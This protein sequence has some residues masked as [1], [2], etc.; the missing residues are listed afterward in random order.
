[1]QNSQRFNP[2]TLIHGADYNPE[3]WALVPGIWDA[4]MRLLGEARLNCVSLGIFSWAELESDEGVYSFEWMDEMMDRL[5]TNG[6]K[7]ILATPS[8][9]KPNW[10]A[11]KYPEIRRVGEDGRRR[12]QGL[13]HNH[14]LTSPIYRKKVRGLNSLLAKRYGKHPALM[15]WH[16]SNEYSGY[17][18][19][20]LC[21]VEFRNWL[22]EKYGTLTAL[23][24]A[25]WSRFWGHTY[26]DW[27]QI[28]RLDGIHAARLDWKRFMTR[29]V[30]T[31]FRNESAPLREKSPHIPTTINM[32]GNYDRYDYTEL[33]REVDFISWDSYPV[34][35]NQQ[36]ETAPHWH[37]GMWTTFFHDHFRALKP[38]QPMLLIE[39]T[40]SQVNW[41]TVSPLKR[42][43]M[44]RTANLLAVSR[45]SQGVCYF[46]FRASRGSS[47][48]YHGTVV[49]HDGRSDT[50]VFR[51][52]RETSDLF[53]TLQPLLGSLPRPEVAVIYDYQ[54]L[55]TLQ[56][57]ETP[58]KEA[59]NYVAT[60]VDHYAPFWKRGVGVDVI[61]QSAD[62]SRYKIVV[63]PMLQ[64]LLPGTAEKFAAFVEN[65]GILVTTY[66][67]GYVNETDLCF[68][69][70]FPGPLRDL[71]GIRIE[72]IDALPNF[73]KVPVTVAKDGHPDLAGTWEARDICELIHLEGAEAIAI[74]DTE[75]YAGMPAVTRKAT[76]R[77]VA[78]HL[79][80]RLDHGFLDALT[81]SILQEAGVLPPFSESLPLGVT[82]QSRVALDGTLWLFLMNFNEAAATVNRGEG[83]W[84]DYESGEIMPAAF[85]LLPFASRVFTSVYPLL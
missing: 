29:Q 22:K 85:E 79:A 56:E 70:G 42:P 24:D 17:C 74:Y 63:A 52:V 38:D 71:L 84:H 25:W 34:W 30:V 64:M 3:Q 82:A 10:M 78:Y 53:Q 12:Q 14:C 8:G 61:G 73:R 54:N 31:F 60:C 67:T 55:W 76:G 16:I 5:H 35:H 50:R 20:Y 32:M 4:D 75:F 19:C 62:I 59:I 36:G 41:A 80:A 44:H 9:A 6:Q 69:G 46:Q 23:N 26:T 28:D 81:T 68:L 51:D 83:P 45:G 27:D 48:K 57:I 33:A 15:A 40:P 21:K 58:V 2:T 18:Y 39:T 11:E 49:S 13:R 43:G 72:E 7:V 77:G 1:M 65:G 47:E 37:V 66:L